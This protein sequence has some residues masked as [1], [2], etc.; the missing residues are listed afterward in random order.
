MYSFVKE[1]AELFITKSLQS[2]DIT[3]YETTISIQWQGGKAYHVYTP[4]IVIEMDKRFK[5]IASE[6]FN[7]C[8]SEFLCDNGDKQKLHCKEH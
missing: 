5:E 1:L 3:G 2:G 4:I 7:N 6:I 8:L